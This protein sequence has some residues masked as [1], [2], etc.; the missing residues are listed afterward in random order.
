MILE[1]LMGLMYGLLD[2]LTAP[3]NIP[4]LPQEISVVLQTVLDY[5]QVGFGILANYTH[6]DYLFVL[7]G[8]VLAFDGGLLAYKF[9]MW[10]LR[11]IPVLGIK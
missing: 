11:K 4:L 5:L 3:F 8:I 2:W 1:A 7:Y 6:L 10:V 9:V